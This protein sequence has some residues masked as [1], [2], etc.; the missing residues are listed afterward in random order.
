MKKISIIVAI[1]DNWVIGKDNKLLWHLPDDM[2]WFKKHT[3]G[4][5]V[6]MGRKTYESLPS[7]FRPLPNRKNIVITHGDLS[8]E[9]CVMA[10]SV[11][12]AVEKMD[13]G[14]EN[15]V[16][17][18]GNIYEQFL[19]ITRKL[20]I[21]KVHHNFEGDTFFPAI[22]PG[23]WKLISSEDHPQDEKHAFSFTFQIFERR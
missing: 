5:D 18:G 3:R 10:R 2:K 21:T 14:K 22:D 8:L 9:G 23:Q 12:D 4:C 6:I 20:Y 16:I 17:G 19:P 7:A 11:D 13:A 1:A 15:F